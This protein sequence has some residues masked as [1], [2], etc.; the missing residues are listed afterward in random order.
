MNADI[1]FT[2]SVALGNINPKGVWPTK[3]GD[4]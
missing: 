1:V 3:L 4:H 2:Q